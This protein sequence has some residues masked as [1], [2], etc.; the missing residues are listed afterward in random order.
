MIFIIEYMYAWVL[1]L[2]SGYMGGVNMY[3]RLG[4]MMWTGPAVLGGDDDDQNSSKR[5]VV[6]VWAT[7]Y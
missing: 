6:V 4:M 1:M 2:M 7:S 5:H 3:G